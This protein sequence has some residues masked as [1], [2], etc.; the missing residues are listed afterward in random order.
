[1]KTLISYGYGAAVALRN[2]A[3]DRGWARMASVAVPVISVGNITAGGAGKTPVVEYLAALLLARER[4]VAVVT[5]GYRRATRGSVVVSDG[6]GRVVSARD[7]GDE[8]VQIARKFP[9]LVV[10]ADARRRRGCARAVAEFGAE[11]ILL[12]D[13]FQHRAMRRDLDIVVIDAAEGVAGQHLLP[14]GRLREPLTNLRR[15][16]LILLSK[17]D[18]AVAVE[19]LRRALGAW[20]PA[21]VFATRFVARGWRRLGREGEMP[22]EA[23]AGIPIGS[24]C[25]IGRPAGFRTTL[26][27]LGLAPVIERPFADHHPYTTRDI[28]ALAEDGRRA[29]VRAWVTTEKDAMRLMDT[30]DWR[31]LGDVSYPRMEVVFSGDEEEFV[32]CVLERCGVVR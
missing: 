25:G 1:M 27:A 28:T 14:R 5:R 16:D 2:L 22:V 32:A 31:A 23:L 3:F 12:D 6:R 17:C 8:P 29:G 18:D 20:T 9:S 19:R 24:F 15:A 10:I 30:D 11:C 4:R 21:P 7:G 13:A 26:H